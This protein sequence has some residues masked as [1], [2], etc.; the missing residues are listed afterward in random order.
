MTLSPVISGNV[1][2]LFYGIVYDKHSIVEP[3][4]ERE[5][6]EGL[7]CYR[8]AYI[9]TVFACLAGLAI[10][11]WSIWYTHRLRVAEELAL[12]EENEHLA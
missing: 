7:N 12:V 4:G 1:F 5:C 3:N 6:T 11:V 9:M 10:S 2:N 8:S